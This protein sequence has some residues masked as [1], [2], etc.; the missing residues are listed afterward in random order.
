MEVITLDSKAYKDLVKKIE[1]IADFIATA[2]AIPS[3]E[4]TDVWLDSIEVSRILGISTR[5]LQ[6]LRKENLI[7]YS[8]MRGRCRYRISD[9]ETALNDKLIVCN[10]HTLDEF[11]KN[12]LLYAK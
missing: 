10:P 5:T 8:L 6:R 1:R 9:I 12:Y 4:K 2:E 3:N 7:S 11:R